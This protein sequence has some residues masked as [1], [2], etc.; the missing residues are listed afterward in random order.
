VEIVIDTSAVL[1]VIVAEPERAG[2]VKMTSGHEL[3]APGSIPWEVGNAFSAM[4]KQRRLDLAQA[5]QGLHI[6]EAVRLRIVAIDL[7][8]AIAIA[9]QTKMYA[10]DAY[11]LDCAQRYNAPLLTLDRN[12]KRAAVKVG[13]SLLEV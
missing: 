2:I 11:I 1:A 5:Q 13:V 12:L 9:D 3:I 7:R 8:N 6:F 4:L 10:Y